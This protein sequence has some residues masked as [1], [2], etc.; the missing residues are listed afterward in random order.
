VFDYLGVG[1]TYITVNGGSLSDAKMSVS[2]HSEAVISYLGNQIRVSNLNPG[3]YSLRVES[4]PD[5]NHNTDVKYISVTVNKMPV[6][7]EAKSKTVAL[8]KGSWTVKVLDSNNNPVSNMQ[9][10]LKVYTGKKFI[11]VTVKTNAKGEATYS[12]KKLSKGTHKVIASV[13][14]WGYSANSVTSSI[15]VIKQ[16]ALKFKVKKKISKDGS[17]LSITVKYKNKGINGV[18]LKLKVYD[19]KKL[20]KTVTLKTK[21][22]G[23]YKG[24]AGW[25]TNKLKAGNHKVVIMPASI[26][27]SGSK[28]LKMKIK[29]SAKK[30][31]KWETKI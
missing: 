15:K 9:V 21:T 22:K 4:I 29:K 13:D 16:K 30:Y 27:Y 11:T 20:V 25:G 31:P 7:I 3:S 24:V 10:T 18:K 26:T 5:K 2:G 17:S 28:S 23:K 19:G 8:K 12:T 1:S 6:R 14:N